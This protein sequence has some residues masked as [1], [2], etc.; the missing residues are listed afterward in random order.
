MGTGISRDQRYK[1]SSY[2]AHL[3]IKSLRIYTKSHS[4][5]E[6]AIDH[7]IILMQIR[8]AWMAAWKV[9]ADIWEENPE[10][11]ASVYKHV[12]ATNST[13]E[14]KL[15]LK[16]FVSMQVV[17]WLGRNC[18]IISP[19]MDLVEVLELQAKLL[20]ARRM[21]WPA[22]RLEWVQLMQRKKH[23]HAKVRS[24]AEAEGV[25]DSAYQCH[26][27][28]LRQCIQERKMRKEARSVAQQ[29]RREKEK[30]EREMRWYARERRKKERQIERQKLLGARIER[31]TAKK[32]ACLE[33]RLAKAVR[34]VERALDLKAR[35]ES[36]AT[37]SKCARKHPGLRRRHRQR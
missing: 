12:L 15:G 19:V 20:C 34:T 17:P 27:M 4:A 22:F 36:Q 25:A 1:L 18:F 6:M 35:R 30:R 29:Q 3:H 11:L 2:K 7:Q 8:L 32:M 28:F 24:A 31:Q 14:S 21:S 9:N 13:S 26:Q 23:Y 5:I 33:K 37:K 10:K 16:A